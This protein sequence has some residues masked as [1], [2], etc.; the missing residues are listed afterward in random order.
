MYLSFSSLFKGDLKAYLQDH[1][2]TARSVCERG[3]LVKFAN[4]V[5]AGLLALHECN[6]IHR[7]HQTQ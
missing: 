6:F 5:A 3:L 4:D 2:V 7:F 1:K